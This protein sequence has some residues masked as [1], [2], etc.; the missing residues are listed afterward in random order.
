MD[1]E[2]GASDPKFM[3]IDQGFYPQARNFMMGVNATF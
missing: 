3:G 2:I 1:P